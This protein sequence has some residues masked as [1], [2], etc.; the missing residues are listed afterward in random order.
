MT[1]ILLNLLVLELTTNQA[2]EGEDG[3]GR[4]DNSLSLGGKTDKTLAVLGEGHHRRCCPCTLGVLNDAGS[5][6]LHHCNAR[7]C[8]PQVNTNDGAC[9]DDMSAYEKRSKMS[10]EP[11]TFVLR[12]L[13][14]IGRGMPCGLSQ[15]AAL[16]AQADDTYCI[17]A[18]PGNS[19]AEST[20]SGE[21]G[22]KGGERK[23][24]GSKF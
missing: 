7:V 18:R 11:F 19:Q 14:T 6:T 22:G 15:D 23:D 5:L 16:R 3:V 8:C 21:H 4:V 10:H 24:D 12:F 13:A 17:V 1:R 20:S 2:F 9:S